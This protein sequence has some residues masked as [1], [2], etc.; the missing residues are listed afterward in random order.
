V[1]L[2]LGMRL[3]P[4]YGAEYA[5]GFDAIYP[6]L[7]KELDVRFVPF[8]MEGVAGVPELN[9]EDALHPTA[10]GHERLADNVQN[11]LR[12]AITAAQPRE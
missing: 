7:A 11:A 4:S 2:L 5:A 9:Q 10:R 12:E 8:F 6:R 3:P 1:P